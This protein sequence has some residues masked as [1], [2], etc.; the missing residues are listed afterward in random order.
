M[1]KTRITPTTELVEIFL[2][3]LFN[4]TDSVTKSSN[5]SVLRGI[6]FGSSKLA[7][8]I[9]KDISIIESRLFQD[10]AFG[11]YLDEIAEREGFPA[12]FPANGSTTWIRVVGEP[13]T[14]YTAGVTT[15]TGKNGVVFDVVKTVSIPSTP[16]P[17]NNIGF[18]YVKVASQTVGSN[19]NVDSLTLNSVNPVPLGHIY[20]IN[21]YAATG[22]QDE[23][24]DENMR[25]RLFSATNILSRNTFSGFEQFLF[26]EN[27]RILRAFHHGID[28][29]GR[30]V[31]GVI[32]V[33]G[34]NLSTPE[35]QVIQEKLQKVLSLS[36]NFPVSRYSNFGFVINNIEFTP[37]DVDFRV[38][39]FDNGISDDTRREIQINMNKYL[40]YR[41]WDVFKDKVDWDE[42]L[43]ITKQTE[44]VK[45]VPD[46][47][48]SPSQD[49]L[50]QSNK[51]P[52]IRSFIMRD[53]LGN[54]IA[55]VSG[56][57][58]PVFYPNT[59]DSIFQSTLISNV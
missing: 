2:E 56:T 41:Y 26:K 5:L 23:E 45:Y 31:I 14:T 17:P 27:P 52:R 20:C 54:I 34:S 25:N 11:E 16:I 44:N 47:N 22:G 9:T 39:L 37:I 43:F 30:V 36:D 46:E 58:N 21:E 7:N 53:L 33:D 57:L 6:A 51:L 19:S 3:N 35:I 32:C 1:I 42:L 49:I 24:N 29:N 55:N 10:T 4:N 59:P 18:A 13:N 48:F 8:K 15:F 28:S 38:E 12:R 40:D 50:I